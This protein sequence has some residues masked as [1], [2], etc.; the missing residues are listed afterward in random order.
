MQVRKRAFELALGFATGMA[1]VFAIAV[2][3]FS[4]LYLCAFGF[5]AALASAIVLFAIALIP[6]FIFETVYLSLESFN[7][8]QRHTELLENILS[9]LQQN[10]TRCSDT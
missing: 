7:E 6:V 8:K 9:K 5:F 2:A 10:N 4:F 1:W 3:I